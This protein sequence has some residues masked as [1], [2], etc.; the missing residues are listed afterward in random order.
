MAAL[1]GKKCAAAGAA[2]AM[3]FI[4]LSVALTLCVGQVLERS[5]KAPQARKIEHHGLDEAFESVVRKKN[6]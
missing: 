2:F 1:V 3:E 6:R 4:L 5:G